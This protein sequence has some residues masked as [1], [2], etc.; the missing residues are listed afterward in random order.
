MRTASHLRRRLRWLVPFV[1]IAGDPAGNAGT[2][3]SHSK[4]RPRANPSTR[5]LDP[6]T[7]GAQRGPVFTAAG[8]TH[9]RN[10]SSFG[11]RRA[12]ARRLRGPNRIEI[13]GG[14]RTYHQAF[15]ARSS[16]NARPGSRSAPADLLAEAPEQSAS[17]EDV[18]TLFVKEEHP[19]NHLDAARRNGRAGVTRFTASH[20]LRPLRSDRAGVLFRRG[21]EPSDL[22]RTGSA[23]TAVSR[24]ERPCSAPNRG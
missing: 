6:K 22:W 8:G 21:V 18:Q 12:C 20:P 13:G 4:L 17:I 5:E 9:P 7:R 11:S 2:A 24:D 16:E 19:G 15:I 10:A 3:R 14:R 23:S 1:P